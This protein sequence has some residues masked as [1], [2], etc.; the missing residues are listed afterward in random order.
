MEK[1]TS[2]S[3]HEYHFSKVTIP[4]YFP[5]INLHYENMKKVYLLFEAQMWHQFASVVAPANKKRNRDF[6]VYMQA[7]ELSKL[8]TRFAQVIRHFLLAA[9]V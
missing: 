7:C 1:N 5:C 4:N 6:D 3:L 9:S 8:K 2:F